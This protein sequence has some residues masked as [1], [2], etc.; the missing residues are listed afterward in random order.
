M[1]EPFRTLTGRAPIVIGHRG[2]AGERPEHT[3][4]SYDV[5]I[6]RGADF[7]EPDLVVTQD[8][9]LIARH[10]P[11][12]AVVNLDG[13]LN[14]TETTTD[15][16][17]RDEFRDRKTTKLLDGR[18]VTGWFAE[19]LTLAEIKTLNAIERL[20]KL[21]GTRFNHH[22]LKVPTLQEVIQLVQQTRRKVGI[23]PETKHPTYFRD[24]GYDI[25]QLLI[26]TLVQHQFIDPTRVFIQS[27]EVG[28]LIDLKHQMM[29]QWGVMLPLIQLIGTTGRPY[30][31]I[32]TGNYQLYSEMLQP[33]G[34]AKIATYAAGIGPDKQWVVSNHYPM[35]VQDAHQA[36]LLVHVYTLRDERV[37]L[38]TDYQNDPKAEYRRLIGFGVDG[39]F[40]DFPG[41]ARSL[42]DREYICP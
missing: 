19:D 16:Y 11:M 39:F 41:T 31:F 12:L 20:P 35:L 1:S 4:E 29:P 36:G 9:I 13:S 6:A 25:S 5:A 8:G 33:Q 42:L 10:E 7:I 14:E 30:D 17:K 24:R 2:A 40:T 37:F 3:L 22:K 23:Y 21:R 38:A 27:F 15:I 34:L 32:D 18:Q 28:N 26:Q